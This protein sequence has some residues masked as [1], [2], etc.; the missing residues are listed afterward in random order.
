MEKNKIIGILGLGSMGKIIAKDLAKNYNGKVVYL[1]RDANSVKDLAKKYNADVR[2]TDVAKPE[3]LVKALKDIDLVIHAVHH[4][5]NLNVMNACLKSKTNYIDLGGLYHYTKEQL[6]LH[7]K[8]RKANLIAV[9]GMGASPGITN[10]MAKYA[11]RFFNKINNIEIK[12]GY[13]DFSD[14]KVE[15]PLSASYSIQTILEE[16]SWNPA[17]FVN[18]KTVFVAPI[19]GRE[20]Y[21]FPEPIG[22]Q[23]PQ[24]TIHSEIATLPFTLMAKNVSFKIAYN[25]DFIDKVQS[26]KE[27]GFL[28]DKNVNIKGNKINVRLATAQ[29]LKELPSPVREHIHEYEIIRVDIEGIEDKKRKT[30]IM[31]AKIEGINETIDKDTGVPPSIVAQM[32]LDEKINK[33]GVYPP[34]SIVPEEDFFKELKKR[35]ILIFMN[36][37]KIN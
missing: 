23:K 14:Y 7:N 13:K 20:S 35:G 10:V 8:F 9:I 4:E 28:S 37:K 29:V 30:I 19:S 2:Y 31:D 21:R 32:I 27:L 3:T 15:S 17:V 34:E 36:D 11:S 6:K 5:F 33:Y 1:V 12:I 22:I 26:L 16:C 18:G 25:D 24:Y